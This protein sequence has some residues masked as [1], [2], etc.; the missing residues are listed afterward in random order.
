MKNKIEKSLKHKLL[1]PLLFI[2]T[3]WVIIFFIFYK[4]Q[5]IPDYVNDII[6]LGCFALFSLVLTLFFI[7]FLQ[8]TVI[9]P[10]T[11]FTNQYA[12]LINNIPGITYRCKLDEDWTMLFMSGTIETL[13]GY[14]ISDFIQNRVRTYASVIHPDDVQFVD[15]EVNASVKFNKPYVIEY[16]VVHQS[17][18][19]RW[20]H[21]RGCGVEDEFGQIAFLD[22]FILDITQQKQ[23]DAE[24]ELLLKIVEDS[25]DFI[26]MADMNANIKYLNKAA[27][28]M[29]GLANNIDI[30]QLKIH[31]MHPE[32]ATNIV[33]EKG[34]P[35]ILQHNFWKSET[36]LLNKITGVE[37]PVSQMLTLHRNNVK[38][39]QVISTIMRDISEA[40]KTQAMML[41]AK[42]AAELLAKSKSEFLANMS[43]EIRTPMNAIIGLSKLALN[44][45]MPN[46]VREFLEKIHL[47]SDSLLGIL[48]DI[49]DFSK[50]EAGK[51]TIEYASFNLSTLFQNLFQLFS[52]SAENKGLRFYISP[53]IN[54]PNY[55]IGDVLRIQ[56][57]LANLLGNAIKFTE[58]GKIELMIETIKRQ[59]TSVTL[60]FSVCDTGIGIDTH[61]TEK[62]FDSFNQGDTSI[63]RR[64]GGTGLGLT[65]SQNLLKLMNSELHIKS[66]LNQGSTF[67]FDLDLAISNTKETEKL[68]KPMQK[69]GDL[70][71]ILKQLGQNITGKSILL[72][73]DNKLNQEIVC[74]F[75]MLAGL[76]VDK[77]INGYAVLKLLEQNAYDAILMDVNM[78]EMDGIEATRLIRLQEKYADLPIIALTAGVTSE[79]KNKCLMCGMNDFATKPVNPVEL[80]TI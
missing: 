80:L 63:T 73:E 59:E 28:N 58:K 75:L 11:T 21:E 5:I 56:Q 27:K 44:K 24:R 34:I 10:I 49:L 48:N 31:D 66:A 19:I 23:R 13:T 74:G 78:P 39:P 46:D 12:A 70:S 9:T 47:S 8:K 16:R 32:W 29:V 42:N 1:L 51:L 30:S 76:N 14:A 22:G 38:K 20:V 54:L 33:L 4:T 62:L 7:Q 35:T 55:L 61:F 37:I 57:V 45:E 77:A 69:S 43:H 60:R 18:E 6:I 65:I 67:Y 79:E 64:F 50:L 26:G 3:L 36:A 15:D 40:R 2:N 72:A 53:N 68:D 52:T 25:P 71:L 17:G 41:E